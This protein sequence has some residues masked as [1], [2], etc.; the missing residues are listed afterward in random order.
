MSQASFRLEHLN[1]PARDPQGL[2]NWY[3]QTFGLRAD[4][5]KV[6]ADGV[7]IVFQTGEPLARSP[8]IHFGLRLSSMKELT[9]WAE[10]FNT[11]ITTGGEYNALRTSDPE[12]NCI[13]LYCSPDA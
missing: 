3:A 1:L 11:K 2:A 8:E 6:R 12:G 9:V 4:G 13:E 5:Q 10:K 7:L